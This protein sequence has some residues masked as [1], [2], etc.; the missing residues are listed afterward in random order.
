[1]SRLEDRSRIMGRL[2]Q[3]LIDLT[4]I[5]RGEAAPTRP[6]P[7][8]EVAGLVRDLYLADARAVL[9][10]EAPQHIRSIDTAQRLLRRAEREET[11]IM[12]LCRQSLAEGRQVATRRH[13]TTGADLR[14]QNVAVFYLSALPWTAERQGL[15]ATE[16][17][18]ATVCFDDAPDIIEEML[19]NG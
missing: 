5:V 15:G 1:M 3:I 2:G 14:T 12:R 9:G 10:P 13:L 17:G 7:W 11:P 4:P 8:A 18:Q 19:R 6:A 16:A